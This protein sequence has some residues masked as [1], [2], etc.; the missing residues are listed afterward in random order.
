MNYQPSGLHALRK[1]YLHL[2]AETAEFRKRVELAVWEI[3][4]ETRWDF[5]A[6]YERLHWLLDVPDNA[7]SASAGELF[8]DIQ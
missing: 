8:T 6:G 5:S 1:H 4:I 7:L 3:Y 2:Y